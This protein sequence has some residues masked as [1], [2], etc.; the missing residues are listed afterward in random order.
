MANIFSKVE[1]LNYECQLTLKDVKGVMSVNNFMDG[2]FLK[3]RCT[4]FN[5]LL[6]FLKNFY[7]ISSELFN[8]FTY[9]VPL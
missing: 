9:F 1:L 4:I 3:D 8:V 5:M 2:V 7:S 6:A